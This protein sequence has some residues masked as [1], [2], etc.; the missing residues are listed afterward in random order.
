MN[1]KTLS[2]KGAAV[3]I[4]LGCA[5][6]SN[7]ATVV[8]DFN[9]L[10]ACGATPC[11]NYSTIAPTYGSTAELAVNFLPSASNLAGYWD[12]GY[13]SLNGVA[14]QNNVYAS[15]QGTF[16]RDPLRISFNA[17]AGYAITGFKFDYASYQ[18]S[19]GGPFPFT[20]VSFSTNSLGYRGGVYQAS[21]LPPTAL[22]TFSPFLFD[23]RLSDLT[24]NFGP[25]NWQMGIDNITVQVTAVPEPGEW[26]MMLAGLG[27]VGAIARKRKSIASA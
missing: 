16:S 27:I 18:F 14:F 2:L 6:A 15:G 19:D 23:G 26:A 7:A 5:S 8:L 10:N 13:G 11:S 9:S 21:S 1:Y 4:L 3:A 25:D 17:A 24:L 22:G 12:S 20:G